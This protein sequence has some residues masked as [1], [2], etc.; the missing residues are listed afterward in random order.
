MKYFLILILIFSI[1]IS[2]AQS[3]ELNGYDTINRID[4]NNLKQGFWI[5]WGRMKKLPGYADNSKVEE[6]KFIDSK[7]HG[8][9]KKYFPTGTLESEITFSNN[10]VHGNYI[11]YYE[12][13]K[14]QEQ[15]TLANGSITGQYRRFYENGNLHQDWNYN[16]KG[17]REGVQKYYYENG[18]IMIEGEWNNG[19]ESG[20]VKEY[21]ENGEI[22]AEK[23][24]FNGTI[25]PAT[26]KVFELKKPIE[27][28]EE[29]KLST[30]EIKPVIVSKD[31]TPNMGSFS[32]NGYAKL[33]G[34]D[35]QISKEGTFKNYELIDGKHYIYNN[36]GILQRIAVYKNGVHIGDGVISDN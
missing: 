35:K 2:L 11:T 17:K 16:S 15:G 27:K 6:G 18:K 9:W 36:D 4:A 5:F 23:N 20:I 21:Y 14:I 25:D 28:K 32:G 10:R 34:K 1:K 29:V 8:L 24:F 26:T 30:F 31:E 33:F 22:R 7:K 19:N 12:N 13:G 3:Y